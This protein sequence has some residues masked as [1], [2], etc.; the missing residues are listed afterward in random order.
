MTKDKSVPAEIIDL[1]RRAEE[2]LIGNTVAIIPHRTDEEVLQYHHELQVHQI[3]LEVQ[4]AQLRQSRDEV[5]SLLEMYTELYDFAP[6]GYFT[7]DRS[8]TINSANLSGASL[9][10]IERSCLIGRR[11][12]LFISD[13]ARPAFALFLGKVFTSLA[14]E[15][16]E[17]ALLKEGNSP[18]FV[19]IEA[20]AAASGE[21]CH[22]ALIDITE[23]KLS[24][25][26]LRESEERLRLLIDGSKD[27]AIF[28]LDVDGRVTSWNEGAKRLKGWDAEEI[29]GRRFS[30]FYT[31]EAVAAGHPEHEL[32][33]AAAR[34]RY[35][36]E[37]WRLRRDG[38]KFMAE[39]IITAIRDESGELRGFAKITR[40]ITERK[41]AEEAFRHAKEGAEAAN[42]A[43]SQF[44]AN[45]SHELRTPMTGLL[46]MLQLALK[47]DLAPAPRDYLETTLT[48]ANSLLRVLNDILV[49]AKIEAGKLTIKENAF[50][51]QKC[52]TE[53]VDLITPEL[54]RKGL[55]FA[56]LVA[57]E[58]KETFIG[59]ESRLRQVLIN[60]IGNA[61]KFTEG[62]KVEV[63]VTAGGTISKGRREF[64]FAFT[65]TGIGIPEDKK[66]L[67]FRAFSQV[68]ASPSRIYGGT[69]LGLAISREIVE[70]MGGTISFVSEEG[71]GSTFTF[72]IPLVEAGLESDVLPV[73][74]PKST[75]TIVPP[76][77]GKRIPR[78]LHAEDDP[79]IREILGQMLRQAN[80]NIDFAEDGLKAVEMW[81]KGEYDLILM[82]VQMP[83][84]NGLEATRAIREKEMA[85]GG[86]TPIIAVTAHVRKEDK[87]MCLSAGMD[88]FISKPIDF[89]KCL[90]LIGEI[91]SRK[92]SG[93]S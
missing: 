59:D 66:E 77:K 30:L 51:L 87:E 21:E 25:D 86:H 67:L 37:G 11:F 56:L 91:I 92:S 54:R 68:D 83:R 64:T 82:D 7:L 70:L 17:V 32:E 36:E 44:L 26:A 75:E 3:E 73:A 43:K 41:Q 5:E 58:A 85:R 16:H 57:E 62:G 50:S 29:L 78:I 8:G 20:M 18:I 45:M 10:G 72:T 24:E 1:R 65:D 39:V 60:L 28:M 27:H 47:E 9:L 93:V 6:V 89:K 90:Q 81:E 2:L 35:A 76:M 63:R 12:G 22:I 14:K 84:L 40:D 38:S 23:R 33:I 88:A 31:E 69:G 48:S 4:N 61:V 42:R 52:I 13:E 49:M 74:E 19:Q 46:G 71:M 80:F 53:A 15:V 34:G 79:V 55:D